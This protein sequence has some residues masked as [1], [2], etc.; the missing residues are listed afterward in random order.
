MVA[1]AYVVFRHQRLN[2]I[3]P[4]PRA[5]PSPR[6][7]RPPPPCRRFDEGGQWVGPTQERFLAMVKEY[8]VQCYESPHSELRAQHPPRRT[9]CRLA[10]VQ[11]WPPCC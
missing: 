7:P 5:P 10:P 3:S 4:P 6:L 11:D 8:S 2:P 9:V 1:R